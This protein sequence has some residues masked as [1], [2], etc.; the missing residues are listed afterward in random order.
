M[1]TKDNEIEVKNRAINSRPRAFIGVPK[2]KILMKND[3]LTQ[4]KSAKICNLIFCFLRNKSKNLCIF[5]NNIRLIFL[6]SFHELADLLS[7]RFLFE[8]MQILYSKV[9][10]QFNK[11]TANFFNYLTRL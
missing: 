1:R 7:L 4:R 6:L 2:R 8:T 3:R 10:K 9:D 5:E 11:L